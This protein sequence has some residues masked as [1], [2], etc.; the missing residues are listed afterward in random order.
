MVKLNLAEK[1]GIGI[2]VFCL[3]FGPISPSA[4]FVSSQAVD[5]ETITGAQEWTADYYTIDHE[6]EIP[7]GAQLTVEKGITIVFQAGG[8]INVR[9]K[10]VVKG[11]NLNP[12]A[13][14]NTS[15]RT[16]GMINIFDAGQARFYNAEI[17]GGG[18]FEPDI[19]PV[20]N[21]GKSFFN[22]ALAFSSSGAINVSGA[23]KLEM[24]G[25]RIHHNGAGV[26]IRNGIGANIRI[27]RTQFYGN[28]DYDV[29]V[30]ETQDST[31]V[32]LRYN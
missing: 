28:K 27:N 24:Q 20:K 23:G 26:W 30:L 6:V 10:L 7:E 9:G 2:L 19:Y 22:T 3:A 14:K 21:D 29:I 17:D 5:V 25:C 13:I 8:T 31:P 15:V 12:V 4:F 32:D 1:T 18:Y 16:N 11:T